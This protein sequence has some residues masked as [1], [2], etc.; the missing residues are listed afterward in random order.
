MCLFHHSHCTSFSPREMNLAVSDRAKRA[1]GFQ[2]ET[3]GRSYQGYARWAPTRIPNVLRARNLCRG[4]PLFV[5]SSVLL[6]FIS[7]PPSLST[8]LAQSLFPFLSFFFHSALPSP[9]SLV[10]SF[11]RVPAR[12]VARPLLR[13]ECVRESKGGGAHACVWERIAE[14]GKA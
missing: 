12:L 9:P 13:R 3:V 2:G 8:A 10:A 14:C 6:R 1:R 5:S 7:L 4:P 11:S